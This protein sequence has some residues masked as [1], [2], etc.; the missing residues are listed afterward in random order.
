MHPKE[1]MRSG[2]KAVGTMIKIVRNPAIAYMVRNAGLDFVMLD[3][4]HGNYNFETLHDVFITANALGVAG[5]VR[6]PVGTKDYISRVLDAGAGGVMVPMVETREQAETL[7]KYAK[8]S[9][10]GQRGYSAS[11][12]HTDYRGGKHSEVMANANAKVVAI[13]QI[14]TATAIQ[15]IDA[16]A[17]APGLDALLIGPN[18]LSISLGIPGDLMNQIELDAIAKVAAACKK[19]GKFFGLHAGA[20]LLEKFAKDL[21]L[22]M[23]LTDCDMLAQGLAGV[24]KVADGL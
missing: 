6:V 23:S 5:F 2:Q 17:S 21:D 10:I 18:D 4:E 13:A 24:K 11:G 7:V 1:K 20:A 9:P 8:F 14:E 19:H 16:I 22:V 3:C 15:N 12:P